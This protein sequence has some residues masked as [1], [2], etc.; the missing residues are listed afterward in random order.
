M[1]EYAKR[2]A[3]APPFQDYEARVFAHQLRAKRLARAACVVGYVL[4]VGTA[5]AIAVAWVL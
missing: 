5:A 4:F 1:T 2:L 3:E